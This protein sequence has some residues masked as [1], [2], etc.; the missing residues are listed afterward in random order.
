MLTP[1]TQKRYSG[2][3]LNTSVRPDIW[4]KEDTKPP[5]GAERLIYR[6]QN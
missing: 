5:T 3:I 1:L 4:S 6:Q 2:Y